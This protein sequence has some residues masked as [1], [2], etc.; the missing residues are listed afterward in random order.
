MSI[1]D[2]DLEGTQVGGFEKLAFSLEERPTFSWNGRDV[3]NA[4]L[5]HRINEVR[6]EY[7]N[8]SASTSGSMGQDKEERTERKVEFKNTVRLVLDLASR[9]E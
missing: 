7:G 2:I 8:V 5:D 6:S 9:L 1:E 4:R 3:S